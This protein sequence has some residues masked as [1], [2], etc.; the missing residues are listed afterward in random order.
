L[1][2]TA[3]MLL[4]AGAG[5][6]GSAQEAVRGTV[7]MDRWLVSSPFPVDTSGAS[8][9]VDY[10][11]APGE[12]AVQPD[13]GR[14]VAGADWTLV[15]MDSTAVLDLE[16]LRAAADGPVV[17]YAHAYVRSVE[18]RTISLTWR[19]LEC[20]TVHA[21]LNGRSLDHAPREQAGDDAVA[22]SDGVTALVRVGRGYNTLLFRAVSGDCRF[23]LEASISGRVDGIRVQ[24][25]R[26]YGDTRTGPAPWVVTDPDAGPE[27]ILGWKEG[28]LFG[29][30]GVRLTAFAVT[31]IERARLKAKTRGEEV[32]REVEWLEPAEPETILMPFAFKT[33]R[34]ALTRGSG[35]EVELEWKDGKSEKTLTL[36]PAVLLAAFHSPIRLLGWTATGEEAQGPA[37]AASIYDEEDEPHPL[38]NLMPLPSTSGQTLVGEWKVPGWLSGFTLR[39]D[40]GGAPGEYRVDSVPVDGP[41]IVLCSECGKGD[42]IQIVVTTA[43]EWDRFPSVSIA[44]LV[45]PV[46]EGG[47]QA[48]EWLRLLDEKGSRKYRERAGTNAR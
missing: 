30:A 16:E 22:N 8:S 14:T 13:R 40:T 24:A 28:E 2:V 19:G 37:S 4:A 32:K 27:P 29:V 10:L 33:L 21:W 45:A 34:E 47:P 43:G 36:D 26:P 39:L 46:A 3:L 25:S 7:A 15:R 35:M 18:D 5:A 6:R 17:G 48:A 38:S 31:A 1:S 12:V 20:T 23:G 11:S 42:R 44:G 9:D 41:E